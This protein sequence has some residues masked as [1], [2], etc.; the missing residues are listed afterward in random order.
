MTTVFDD[1][2]AS[3]GQCVGV[4]RAVNQRDDPVAPAPQDQRGR[5]HHLESLG[6]LGIMEERVPPDQGEAIKGPEEMDQR[7]VGIGVA[8]NGRRQQLHEVAPVGEDPLY[9][10]VEGRSKNSKTGDPST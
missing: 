8:G 9:Q 1:L 6:E 3:A 5:G 2:K 7:G 4:G 10:L